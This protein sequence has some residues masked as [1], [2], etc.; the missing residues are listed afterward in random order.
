MTQ[1]AKPPRFTHSAALMALMAALLYLGSG[2][3]LWLL[4]PRPRVACTGL[5][6]G[7]W[8]W[9]AAAIASGGVLAPVLLMYGLQR[10]STS[11]AALLLNLEGVFT[12]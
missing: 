6:Q 1:P 10:T 12:A 2:V 4:R 7:D 5:I 9:L 8:P 11:Q 3:G